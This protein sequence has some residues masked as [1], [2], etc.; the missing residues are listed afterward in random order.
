MTPKNVDSECLVKSGQIDR[1]V[2]KSR[3]GRS[4]Q[5]WQGWTGTC[6]HDLSRGQLPHISRKEAH[7]N[8]CLQTHRASSKA[9]F[10]NHGQQYVTY[11]LLTKCKAVTRGRHVAGSTAELTC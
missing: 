1:A 7:R 4:Q 5:L 6:S 3:S 11:F 8:Q 9:R 2:R 10:S